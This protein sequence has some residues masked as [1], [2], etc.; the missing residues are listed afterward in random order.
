MRDQSNSN[1]LGD[2]PI[3]TNKKSGAAGIVVPKPRRLPIY[4]D[5]TSRKLAVDSNAACE[6]EDPASLL[7]GVR[8]VLKG[9]AHHT[10]TSAAG[11]LFQRGKL[12]EILLN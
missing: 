2:N 4:E 5:R 1:Q 8:S 6:S 10:F 12:I 9:L 7:A 11:N 3:R